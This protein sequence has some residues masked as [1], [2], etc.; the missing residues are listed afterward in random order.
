[1]NRRNLDHARA[2][3]RD[4]TGA[5]H[6]LR[7]RLRNR[8]LLGWKF[9]R[10]HE[11]GPYVADFV[12]TD[13]WPVVELDGGQ[14]VGNAAADARRTRWLEQGGCRMLSFRN[15]DVLKNLD[16]VLEQI[17]CALPGTAPHPDPLPGGEREQSRCIGSV[18]FPPLPSG[19]R[20]G[21]RGRHEAG[22]GQ[23]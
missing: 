5:E 4:Q 11:V 16:D 17:V 23:Q 18:A 2:L 21:V 20:V 22:S 19:E 1:M 8:A 15:G 13:A 7:G 9:R 14:H 3:R 10:Q 12:C 6:G